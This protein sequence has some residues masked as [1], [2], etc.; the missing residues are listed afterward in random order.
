MTLVRLVMVGLFLTAAACAG[1][2]AEN[3]PARAPL[4]R[5]A[6]GNSCT[7]ACRA[8]HNQCRIATKGSPSCDVQ[9][10]ACMQ[11]CISTRGR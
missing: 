5:L 6:Q 2:D 11:R 7:D 1:A 3:A 9:L 10:Q 4:I 8:Q